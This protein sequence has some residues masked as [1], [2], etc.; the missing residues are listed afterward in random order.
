MREFTLK[1]AATVASMKNAFYYCY[2]LAKIELPDSAPAMTDMTS[3]C[4]SCYSLFDLTLPTSMP[5]VTNWYTA[6][7]ACYSLREVSI[8]RWGT[9]SSA[10]VLF[11]T[12]YALRKVTLPPT[13]ENITSTSSMFSSCYALQEVNLPSA[14]GSQMQTING[15]FS[16]CRSLVGVDLPQNFE[17]VRDCNRLFDTCY[18]LTMVDL[19]GCPDWGAC[20]NLDEFC[21]NCS[22]LKVVKLPQSWGGITNGNEMFELC[23]SVEEV[24]LPTT[25]GSITNCT[26]MF[27]QNDRLRILENTQ[28]LG[29]PTTQ[30][31]FTNCFLYDYT[32]ESDITIAAAVSRFTL[33]GT[34]TYPTGVKNIRFTN[35]ASLFAG[36]TISCDVKYNNMSAA[37]INTMFGDL[38]TVT[39]RTVVVTGNPGAATCD[40]SI[41]TAKGWTV[42]I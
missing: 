42:T 21:Q 38:P 20:T 24:T 9:T 6:F 41:A 17:N 1:T 39:G 13:W 7:N 27:R 18:S 11:S 25:I 19:G 2:D 35:P 31:A 16:M 32:L 33:V 29:H 22:A 23:Q 28:S 30:T 36:T 26:D 40:T 8:P 3:F 4:R 5:S 15:M 34:A 37:A 10:A 12:C 14:W